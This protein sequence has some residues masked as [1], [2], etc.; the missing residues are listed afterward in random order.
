M[1]ELPAPFAID[2]YA[3]PSGPKIK[4][5]MPVASTSRLPPTQSPAAP[6]KALPAITTTIPAAQPTKTSTSGKASTSK[7]TPAPPTIKAVANSTPAHPPTPKMVA[8]KAI[9]PKAL[10]SSTISRPPAAASNAATPLSQPPVN[11]INA[12]PASS[13]TPAPQPVA[14]TFTQ[15]ST[16]A[17][18]TAPAATVTPAAPTAT[19]TT[20][21][22]VAALA[23]TQA[24]TVSHSPVPPPPAHQLDYVRLQSVPRGRLFLLSHRDGVK[25]WAIRL[26][27]EEQTLSISDVTFIQD[28]D[29]SSGDED[30]MEVDNQPAAKPKRGRGR[31]PKTK[32]ETAVTKVK[33][34][35]GKK[36]PKL[37]E[38]QVKLN[39]Q[40]KDVDGKD[41]WNI[42]VPV[43]NSTLEVGEKGGLIWKVYTQRVA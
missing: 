11:G 20:R 19:V 41:T 23:Q 16:P 1:S 2:R 30:D 4:I 13:A 14:T 32:S 9:E 5:K 3:K 28:E 38:I 37:G 33:S 21:S 15:Y 31:P 10:R 7:P 22:Q 25:S 6:P 12:A 27:P 43:G 24:K 8:A 39:G 36:K 26:G 18:A 34:K 35:G 40:V 42:S 17:Q 29:D